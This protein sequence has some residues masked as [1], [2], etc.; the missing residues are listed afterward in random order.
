MKESL[1]I[2]I[3][4]EIVRACREERLA[5]GAHVGEQTFA[6]RLGVSRTPV[7][8]ALSYLAGKG[9]L[10]HEPKRG[11]V[12]EMPVGEIPPDP[13]DRDE[14][15]LERI[16]SDRASSQI[17]QDVSENELLLRY[18]VSRGAVR[19]A[20]QLLAAENLVFR[21]RGHGWRFVDSLDTEPAIADS[22]AFRIVVECGALRQAD[23][24][25][26][27]GQLRALR[28]AHL[29]LLAKPAEQVSKEEWFRINATFHEALGQWSRNRFFLRAIQ[30]QNS[31]RRMH[32]YADFGK[33]R[34]REIR[35]SCEE[36]LAI[37]DALEA[38]DRA[39]AERHL[40]DHLADAAVE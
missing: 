4:H 26:E 33:L 24:E 37:L 10:R 13:T 21:Q 7:R 12:V 1:H 17:A 6:K 28:Q 38:G 16:M 14:S 15:L 25:V 9:I 40:R 35:Q 31:L 8:R 27:V 36:H 5:I 30:Q 2:E 39:R 34:P 11:F 29:A 19:K 20:L 23:Y 3:A 32:Q 18:G 22:Y